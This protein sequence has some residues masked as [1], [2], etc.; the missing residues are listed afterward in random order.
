[1]E[2]ACFGGALPFYSFTVNHGI[3]YTKGTTIHLE[4]TY[5]AND[6]TATHP[7][8]IKYRVIY[9]GNTYD[10]PELPFGEQNEA[11]CVH[12][13][14]GML[15]DGR[16]GG[17][18]QPRANSG[19]ALTA[20]W[21]NITYGRCSVEAEFAL[22]P[23]TLNKNSHGQFVCDCF[24]S[25]T[26][27]NAVALAALAAPAAGS[28]LAPGTQAAVTWN[29]DNSPTVDL[30]STYDNGVTWNVEAENVDNTGSYQWT[31]PD[32]LS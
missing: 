24:E 7:A 20:T 2:I 13:L 22:R 27:I 4:L 19:A 30:I 25:S 18:F 11:E 9:N 32:V 31:V 14:W 16:A 12:G 5:H 8:S 1:G 3:T 29:R 15:N 28:A 23:S 21:S 17:Y 10:S 6:L 26:Q